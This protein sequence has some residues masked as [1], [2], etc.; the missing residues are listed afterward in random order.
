MQQVTES[1]K[2]M[3]VSNVVGA[4]AFSHRESTS[5][6]MRYARYDLAFGAAG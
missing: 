6:Y 1:M 4:K 2:V 5:Q 3:S